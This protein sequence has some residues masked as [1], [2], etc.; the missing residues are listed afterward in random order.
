M[1]VA[2][3][4]SLRKCSGSQQR[5]RPGKSKIHPIIKAERNKDFDLKGAGGFGA[6]NQ[7]EEWIG[8][9]EERGEWAGWVEFATTRNMFME[10]S[11]C[12]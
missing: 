12:S 4:F 2:V 6:D 3:Y 1:H 11:N 10:I 5:T 7:Q 9:P 8:C